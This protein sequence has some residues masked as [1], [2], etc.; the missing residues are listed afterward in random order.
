M[1]TLFQ[2]FILYKMADIRTISNVEMTIDETCLVTSNSHIIVNGILESKGR[3]I[4]SCDTKISNYSTVDDDYLIPVD[5]TTGSVNITLS[6]SKKGRII[7][8]VDVGGNAFQNNI[9]ITGIINNSTNF[10][11]NIPYMSITLWCSNFDIESGSS[12]WFII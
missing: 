12:L 5:T 4:Y 8:I 6:T 11:M 10:I 3:F 2:I 7:H 1:I 9:T